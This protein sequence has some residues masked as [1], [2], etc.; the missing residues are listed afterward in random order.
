MIC[1]GESERQVK[2]IV[3]NAVDAMK[4]KGERPIGVEGNDAGR[5]VLVDYGDVVLHVFF[6]SVRIYYDLEGLW[7]DAPR[8]ELP[9]EIVTEGA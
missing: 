4:E 8:L 5:W 3:G 9:E 7:A 1:S 6:E 2:A